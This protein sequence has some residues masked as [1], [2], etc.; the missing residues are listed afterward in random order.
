MHRHCISTYPAN[1][2][3]GF[4]LIELLV[5]IAIIAILISLL[6]PA[7]QQAREAARRTQCRNNLKQ[8]GLA[9]HNYESSH[10][11]LPSGYIS[12][13]RY[14]QITTLAADDFDAVT[15]DG[16]PGW[17]WGTLLLPYLDQAPL[18][19]ALN[20]SLP[21]WDLSHST[22]VTTKLPAFLCPSVS[23]SHDALTV[24]DAANAPLL[25]Q[26]RQV[27]LGRSHYVA[28]H[29]QEECWGDC[30]G[31]S[32]GHNGDVARIA[33]GPFYRNS[34]TRFR[35]VADGL[36]NTV[37]L[38][39]HTSRLSDKTWV[40]VVPSAVVFPRLS[41]PDNAPESA[42]GLV[43]VHS[44]PAIG[45]AD[46]FGNPIIHPP[47]YPTLHVCQMQ[48]EHTGGAHCLMGDGAVRFISENIHRPTF[49]AMTS[50]REGEVV[51]EY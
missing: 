36:S 44:G 41:S 14:S 48:S 49:A 50:I 17:G 4:T 35:D 42:A 27:R 3:K 25:K 8:L 45:E 37:L 21:I 1:R 40:G 19:T 12:F 29:G 6:L 31:P 28:S 5:V 46:L 33:D 47:N 32:G 9:V 11:T 16:T 18:A 10:T 39:E 51:G 34:H 20:A 15:W 22:A 7:V 24:V 43:F 13:G 26:G 38:G 23:G 30:G 2:R